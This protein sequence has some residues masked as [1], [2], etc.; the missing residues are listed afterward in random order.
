[1]TTDEVKAYLWQVHKL[2]NKLQRARMD[3]DKL[4]SAVEYRSPSFE[5]AGGHGSNDKLGQAM[6]RI[7]EYEAQADV[8]AAEYT[9]KYDEVK[10]AIGT[11]END[12]LEQLLELRYLHYMKWE[13]IAARM[14]YSERQV[15]RLHG[16]ALEKISKSVKDVPQCP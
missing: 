1:M 11:L 12:S 9:A 2:D 14:N 5:G 16:I 6:T 4:R 7:V 8:L 10:K 3:L 15:T 13:Y